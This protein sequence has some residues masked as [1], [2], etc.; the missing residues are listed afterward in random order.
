MFEQNNGWENTY[1]VY[2]TQFVC[3]FMS[4]LVTNK[5]YRYFWSL[6][7]WWEF[8]IIGPYC[9]HDVQR[10]LLNVYKRFFLNLSRFYVF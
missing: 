6:D 10:F 2:N 3:K 1:L 5:A 4:I 7:F 9:E 8:K